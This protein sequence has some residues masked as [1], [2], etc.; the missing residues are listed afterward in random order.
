STFNAR[1]VVTGT[2][3]NVQA[4][5]DAIQPQTLVS[6]E[7]GGV[8]L[9]SQSDA[10]AGSSMD[11]VITLLPGQTARVDQGVPL[12]DAGVS[13]PDAVSWTT[14]GLT[15][16]DVPL[17]D[18]LTALERRFNIDLE[19]DPSLVLRATTYVDPEARSVEDILDAICF[20]LNLNYRPILNG[21]RI[22]QGPTPSS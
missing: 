14:G 3:F 21:F 13:V 9:E 15:L 6:L 11:A 1:V 8:R 2:R 4:W 18:A 12:L 20:A 5:R 17:G 22:E 19:A 7:E 16:I 10:N